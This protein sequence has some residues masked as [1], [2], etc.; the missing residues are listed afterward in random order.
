[1]CIRGSA[2]HSNSKF[3]RRMFGGFYSTAAVLRL[4]ESIRM[5]KP[6]RS[7]RIIMYLHRPTTLVLPIYRFIRI[8]FWVIIRFFYEQSQR[9]AQWN[10]REKEAVLGKGEKAQILLV[11]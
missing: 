5:A 10:W 3:V 9:A 11:R 2:R 8:I 1:M 4:V 7:M 6:F